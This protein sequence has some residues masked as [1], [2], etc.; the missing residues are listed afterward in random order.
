MITLTVY[1]EFSACG[2]CFTTPF[3]VTV[4]WVSLPSCVSGIT[5]GRIRDH[6]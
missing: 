6:S 5:D 4:V 2:I 1:E 3:F